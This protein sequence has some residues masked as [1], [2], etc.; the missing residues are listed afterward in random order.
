M[1]S[2]HN[3]CDK[4]ALIKPIKMSGLEPPIHVNSQPSPQLLDA[5]FEHIQTAWS[6]LGTTEP[7]WSVI[8]HQNFSQKNIDAHQH[9]FYQSGQKDVSLIQACLQRN[10]IDSSLLNSCLEYG[11]GVGRVTRWL[12][13]QFSTIHACDISLSHL[14]LATDYLDKK[15]IHNVNLIHIE[16]IEIVD[17]LPKVDLIYSALVLQHNPPPIIEILI[18]KLLKALN[19][20]GIAIF[21]VPTYRANYS[22]ETEKYLQQQAGINTIEMHLLPQ[23]RIFEIIHQQQATLLEIFEDHRAGSLD[24]QRSNTFVVQ[25][26]QS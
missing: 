20:G 16:S 14:Q 8:S 18:E 24:K 19:T 17:H 21:Q 1:Q 15:A 23:Q 5:L 12:A 13:G 26:N 10:Q 6:F 9:E 11:C 4:P 22:F 7:H 2:K 3:N 25:N